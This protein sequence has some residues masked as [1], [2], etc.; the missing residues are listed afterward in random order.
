MERLKWY[1]ALLRL[2]EVSSLRQSPIAGVISLAAKAHRFDDEDPVQQSGQAAR[3]ALPER[4]PAPAGLA[5]IAP[6]V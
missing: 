3:Q 1:M 2:A 6:P 5:T 4:K